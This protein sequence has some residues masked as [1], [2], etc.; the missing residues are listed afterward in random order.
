MQCDIEKEPKPE[1]VSGEGKVLFA[2]GVEGFEGQV[3]AAL[4]L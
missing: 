3:D 2:E 4:M 1:L